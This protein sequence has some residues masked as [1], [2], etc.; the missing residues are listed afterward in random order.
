MN[1]D[2]DLLRRAEGVAGKGPKSQDDLDKEQVRG[3]RSVISRIVVWVFGISVVVTLL[4]IAVS[5]GNA[6]ISMMLE[7]LKIA[8]VPMTALVIGYY[9]P[10]S[11]R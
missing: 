10:R 3:D 1:D 9:L 5:P 7:V 6:M 8:V 2:L 11:G 4:T